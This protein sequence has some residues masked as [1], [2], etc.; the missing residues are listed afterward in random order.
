MKKLVLTLTLLFTFLTTSFAGEGIELNNINATWSRVLP[1]K[2]ICEPKTTSNGFAVITDAHS[3]MS[4]TSQGRIVYEKLLVRA[5]QAFFG[6]LQND[7]IA[8]ITGSSKRLTLLNPDGRELWTTQT[9]FKITQAP[10]SGRD[11]RFFVRGDDVLAC[12]G[13]NGI[14]KW[15]ITTPLQSKI[16]LNELP[17]GSLILM[18]RELDGGKTKALRISPFGELEEEI[19]FAGEVIRA[20]TTPKG[21]LLV[22]TDGT[23]GLFDLDSESNK[24]THRWLFKKDSVQKTN[25]DFFILSQNKEDVVYVNIK[26]STVEIDY[27]NLSDGSIIKS[28]VIDEGFLPDYGWY[29]N[30]GVFIAGA[31]NACFYN[32]AGRYIWSGI[33]PAA[34]SKQATTHTSFTTDNCFLLFG[35]DWSIHAFRTAHSDDKTSKQT[36]GQ[37][38][39]SSFY[40]IN[41]TL[42]ELPLP[43]PLDKKLLEKERAEL[44]NNGSYGSTEKEYASQLLS[45]CTAYKNLMTTTNFGTR[46]EKTV[47]ETDTTGMEN[48]FSQI[49]LFGTD[50]FCDFTAYF[51]RRETNKTIVHTLLRGVVK[52][53]YDPEG[54]ILEALEYLAHNT[55]EKDETILK[56]ICDAVYSV[57]IT[58]GGAA[59]EPLG[60]D[61]LSTLLYP[62][63]TSVVRDYARN[64][65]K[66]LVG[67]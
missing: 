59:I 50:T 40:D 27:I 20:L 3:L 15:K 56:D 67:K 11:G 10:V 38:D 42:M 34:N 36:I 4:F 66:K 25:K 5:N 33:L 30:S 55:S 41:T 45:I 28:F 48:I 39:Y 64:T 2:L 17:N 16:E 57:C 6:V 22:F 60:K 52:N 29:N 13:I 44:L 19:T 31:N 32:N 53:G 47:F 7:F 35:K 23:S 18:L 63:Y 62:K 46:I 21:I 12:Y 14:Q 26:T 49:N 51:L 24:S 1:G 54:K 61:T 9:D 43:I 8:V 58:N 65:L 37:K